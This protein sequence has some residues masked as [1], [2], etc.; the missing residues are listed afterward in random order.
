[1]FSEAESIL[2]NPII[3]HK[4]KRPKK[5]RCNK[6]IIDF[7]LYFRKKKE[8][9]FAKKN[10]YSEK[11]IFVLVINCYRNVTSIS[12]IYHICCCFVWTLVKSIT[13]YDLTRYYVNKSFES[14]FYVR[15]VFYLRWIPIFVRYESSTFVKK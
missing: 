2:L 6:S 3:I 5:L 12:F 7:H 14:A 13:I 4:N 8:Y 10:F 11:F 9:F 1:M 15:H